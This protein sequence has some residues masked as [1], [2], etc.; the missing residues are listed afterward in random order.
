GNR[1]RR[2]MGF[3][4]LLF[5]SGGFQPHGFCYQWNSGLVWLNVL[6]DF[7]IAL[8]Y[9][10]I[11]VTLVWFIRKRRDLPFGWMFVLFGVF[12]VACGMT[13]LMEGRNLWHAQYWLAGAIKAVTG[14]ASIPTAILLGRIVPRAISLPTDQQWIQANAALQKVVEANRKTEMVLRASE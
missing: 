10:T 3:F 9:F 5:A 2:G 12:I 13:R 14:A 6:S 11:P 8:A 4:E 1:R 7:S